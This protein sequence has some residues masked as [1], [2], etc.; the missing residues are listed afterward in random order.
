MH[1]QNCKCRKF[2][3]KEYHDMHTVNRVAN[4]SLCF[5]ISKKF[6]IYT[7]YNVLDFE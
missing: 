5:A 3:S 2:Y 7:T 6:S 4:D 1:I